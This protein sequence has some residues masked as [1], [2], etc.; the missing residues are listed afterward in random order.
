[1]NKLP[2]KLKSEITYLPNQ[3]LKIKY[4]NNYYD[5]I[6]LGLT[7]SL[8]LCIVYFI[9]WMMNQGRDWQRGILSM[10]VYIFVML[11]HSFFLKTKK[12]V[13]TPLGMTFQNGLF[14]KKHKEK[15]LGDLNYIDF[16]VKFLSDSVDLDFNGETIVLQSIEDFPQIIDY[17]AELWDLEYYDTFHTS[18]NTE[19]LTYKPKSVQNIEYRTHLHFEQTPLTIK[20]LDKLNLKNWFEIDTNTGEI[21]NSKFNTSFFQSKKAKRIEILGMSD[22]KSYRKKII[23]KV[24]AIYENDESQY[25]FES[26]RRLAEDELTVLRDMEKIYEALRKVKVLDDVEIVKAIV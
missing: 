6:Q 13:F 18:I 1:M 22:P 7:L 2:I 10:M 21:N 25:I 20:F 12:I 24:A 23:L 4:K 8:F 14:I 19:I 11:F 17:I 26:D 9:S 5:Y 16:E 3:E 15:L